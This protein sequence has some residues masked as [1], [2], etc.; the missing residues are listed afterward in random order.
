[1]ETNL[2]V[3]Y[4][5]SY[6]PSHQHKQCGPDILPGFSDK[7]LEEVGIHPGDVI[8]LK[9]GAVMCGMVQMLRGREL[10]ESKTL[11]STGQT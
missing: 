10:I 3:Q 2:G 5:T 1:M 7:A 9:D 4:A 11:V 6:E 8:C